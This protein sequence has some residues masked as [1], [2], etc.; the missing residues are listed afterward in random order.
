MKSEWEQARGHNPS[1]NKRKKER[2]KGRKKE[3]RRVEDLQTVTVC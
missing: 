3:R 2:K 1:R